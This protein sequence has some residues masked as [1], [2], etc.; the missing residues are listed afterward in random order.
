MYITKRCRKFLESHFRSKFL[1]VRSWTLVSDFSQFF[2]LN[3]FLPLYPIS[4]NG[5]LY[6]INFIVR[7]TAG[8]SSAA[9]CT[10]TFFM[11]KHKN[12]RNSP[13][14]YICRRDDVC[15]P[16]GCPTKLLYCTQKTGRKSWTHPLEVPGVSFTLPEGTQ[17]VLTGLGMSFPLMQI[18]FSAVGRTGNSLRGARTW[19]FCLKSSD[20]SAKITRACKYWFSPGAGSRFG[21]FVFFLYSW[22]RFSVGVLYEFYRAIWRIFC[23]SL[24]YWKCSEDAFCRT[25]RASCFRSK[26]LTYWW[27]FFVKF[28]CYFMYIGFLC[29]G[30]LCVPHLNMIE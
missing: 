25:R 11:W 19:D 4:L 1:P 16:K 22:C 14:T 30:I 26:H 21:C 2:L 20:T 9:A 8:A 5:P 28:P 6:P 17:A 24:T 12:S 15:P 18:D 29:I 10:H 7:D 3:I 13:P 23:E 27:F